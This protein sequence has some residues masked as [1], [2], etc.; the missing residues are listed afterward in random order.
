VQ[1]WAL[2]PEKRAAKAVEFMTDPTWRAYQ[3]CYIDG[4]RLCRRFVAGIPARF[5]HLITEQ[6]LPSQL[7]TAPTDP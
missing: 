1:R 2:R 5:E 3:F 7:V 6:V 4:F